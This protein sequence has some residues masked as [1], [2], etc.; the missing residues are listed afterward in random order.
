MDFKRILN[1]SKYLAGAAVVA[2][3][4]GAATV[5][6]S[7]PAN[8]QQNCTADGNGAGS[9]AGAGGGSGS[10]SGS[11]SAAANCNENN[12]SVGDINAGND[13]SKDYYINLNQG[14]ASVATPPSKWECG[15]QKTEQGG[16]GVVLK[17]IGLGGDYGYS[18]PYG[19][20]DQDA[21]ELLKI[22]R[23]DVKDGYVRVDRREAFRVAAAIFQATG[24]ADLLNQVADERALDP[25]NPEAG[26][27]RTLG[28]LCAGAHYDAHR[29]HQYGQETGAGGAFD[30]SAHRNGQGDA[31][32]NKCGEA[33][34]IAIEMH[35][36]R[37]Q[38]LMKRMMQLR[39]Q[40]PVRLDRK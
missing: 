40:Q 5:G 22:C 25:A 29:G 30:G 6:T 7:S 37:P 20:Q 19:T 10:G 39:D 15:M 38:A 9:G 28:F 2:L 34:E 16:L 14:R 8:A 4:L 26:V 11:G 3:G 32:R 23:D 17:F 33:W 27:A 12:S 13:R 31:G 1:V 24:D 18:M 21:R 35:D 36:D